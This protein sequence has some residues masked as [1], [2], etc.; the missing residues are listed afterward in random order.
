MKS[1]I[2]FDAW[3]N[4]CFIIFTYSQEPDDPPGEKNAMQRDAVECKPRELE[5][6]S[7]PRPSKKEVISKTHPLVSNGNIR[8]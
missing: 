8:I 4:K 1:Q 6:K 7:T 3:V 2:F 5:K